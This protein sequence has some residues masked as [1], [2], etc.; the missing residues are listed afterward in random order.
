VSWIAAAGNIWILEMK[1]TTELVAISVARARR[2]DW[3][4]I[5]V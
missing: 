1:S 4:P 3:T 2:D 5:R